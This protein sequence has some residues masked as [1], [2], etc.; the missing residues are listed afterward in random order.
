MAHPP[1]NLIWGAI[2]TAYQ[3]GGVVA[4]PLVMAGAGL[5]LLVFS[6]GYNGMARRV[7]DRGGMSA[8]IARGLGPLAGAGSSAVAVLSYTALST[9]LLVIL[10]GSARRLIASLFGVQVPVVLCVFLGGCVAAGLT[11]LLLRTLVRVL[12]AVGV[13]QTALVLWFDVMAVGHPADGDVSFA[14][15]DPAWLLSGSLGVAIAFAMS[16][17]VGSETGASYADDVEDPRRSI[18]RATVLSYVLTTVALVVSAWAISVAVGGEQIVVAAKG[19]LD[20]QT[21]G[22]GAPF[23]L[24]VLLRLVG[25]DH[26]A[27][28]VDLFASAL[29]LG[30][31]TSC[32]TQAHAS[33]RQLPARSW[34]S[35]AASAVAGALAL[36][37]VAAGSSNVVVYLVLTS[38]LGVAGLL[39]LTSLSTIV[40]FL[41]AD[42]SEAGFF[43]WEGKVVAA[44]FSMVTIGFVFFYGLYRLPREVPHGDAYGWTLWA[45]PIVA[46]AVGIGLR[47]ARGSVQISHSQRL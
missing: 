4:T 39:M 46:F 5:I 36:T 31:L 44:G 8:F 43:G 3:F 23:A 34:T 47:L 17:F 37:A 29:V 27:L 12:L 2:P 26:A 24:S 33:A 25:S 40:W 21:A 45:A 20:S 30:C 42:D 13:V 18:P 1:L 7:S 38:G 28:V 9:S 22:Q 15:L 19:Q 32:T 16:S 35:L 11:R 10:G 14:A 41:R 6:I